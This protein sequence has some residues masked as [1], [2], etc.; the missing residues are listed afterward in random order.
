MIYYSGDKINDWNYADDNII[1]VYRHNAVC[2]YKV[3]SGG[4]HQEPCYAVV[5]DIEQYS[6]TEFVDVYDKTTE[7]WYK[8][9]NLNDVC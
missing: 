2:Y 3:V 5:D 8:L 4:S 6:S 9:N 7:K 1:K